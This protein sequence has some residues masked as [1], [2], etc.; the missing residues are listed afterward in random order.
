MISQTEF[1]SQ[2]MTVSK[3]AMPETKKFDGPG[4]L[5]ISGAQNKFAANFRTPLPKPGFNS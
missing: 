1:G 3:Q 5:E 2:A 4:G